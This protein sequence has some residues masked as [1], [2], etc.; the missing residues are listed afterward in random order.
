MLTQLAGLKPIR[1]SEPVLR[2]LYRDSTSHAAD[3]RPA[4]LSRSFLTISWREKPRTNSVLV[5]M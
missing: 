1:L 3:G 2:L 4:Y 5:T